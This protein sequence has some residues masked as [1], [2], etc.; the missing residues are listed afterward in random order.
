MADAVELELKLRLT[1]RE[2]EVSRS[3]MSVVRCCLLLFVW[4]LGL[5]GG[6][7][8]GGARSFVLSFPS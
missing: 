5:G 7:V 2:L 8:F 3:E 1:E 4:Y 6:L